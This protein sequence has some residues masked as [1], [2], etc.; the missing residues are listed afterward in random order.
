LILLVWQPLRAEG[1]HCFDFLASA[2]G[3]I[4]FLDG[5]FQAADRNLNEILSVAV[6]GFK[7]STL[8]C[9]SQMLCGDFV[10]LPVDAFQR[11]LCFFNLTLVL[12][13]RCVHVFQ[14]LRL[15]N[16]VNL[17][18]VGFAH[19]FGGCSAVPQEVQGG[20]DFVQFLL[21]HDND[22]RLFYSGGLCPSVV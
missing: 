10:H 13:N 6:A 7:V 9:R 3:F 1:L 20:F 12:G 21:C 19:V 16:A 5:G 14:C 22:L 18:A 11:M 8:R 4:G 17:K 2:S 15:G